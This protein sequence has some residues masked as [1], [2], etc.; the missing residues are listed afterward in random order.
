MQLK[1]VSCN[2]TGT[3]FYI[4]GRKVSRE[5]FREAKENANGLDCFKTEIKKTKQGDKI[6]Q[7]C[8]AY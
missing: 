2:E 7:Y 1:Y 4:D 3:R 6:T 8:R 5:V